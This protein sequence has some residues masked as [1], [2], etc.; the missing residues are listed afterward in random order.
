MRSVWKIP[1]L[2]PRILRNSFSLPPPFLPFTRKKK[3][4][5]PAAHTYLRGSVIPSEKSLLGKRVAVY[6]GRQ[7]SS[8][9]VKRFMFGHKF[10]EFIVTKRLGRIIHTPKKKKKGKAKKK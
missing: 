10:G 4:K 9:I 8:F 7:F 5:V 3:Q 6:N 1:F 2:D